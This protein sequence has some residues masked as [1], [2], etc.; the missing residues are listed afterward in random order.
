MIPK[1]RLKQGKVLLEMLPHKQAGIL[2]LPDGFTGK[3]EIGKPM[4]VSAIVRELGPWPQAKKTGA[5]IAYD[6]K[7]GDRV[8]F[9]PTFGTGLADG[10]T[11]YR[12]VSY[13]EIAALG[14]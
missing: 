6:F 10:P 3:D 5:T 4:L 7:R 2:A 1:L 11:K 12:I 14:G 8:L 13:D 9:D